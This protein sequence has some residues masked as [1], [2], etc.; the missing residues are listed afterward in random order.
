MARSGCYRP[1]LRPFGAISLLMLVMNAMVAVSSAQNTIYL[2]PSAPKVWNGE[3][4]DSNFSCSRYDEPCAPPAGAPVALKSEQ[5]CKVVFMPGNYASSLISFLGDAEERRFLS[6]SFN[7]SIDARSASQPVDS[8]SVLIQDISDVEFKPTINDTR[9]SKM[10][11]SRSEFRFSNPGSLFIYRMKGVENKFF[12]SKDSFSEQKST[13]VTLSNCE[14]D[15]TKNDGEK[16]KEATVNPA[17]LTFFGQPSFEKNTNVQLNFLSSIINLNRELTGLIKSNYAFDEISS[18]SLQVNNPHFFLWF[19]TSS[20]PITSTSA[21]K[22]RLSSKTTIQNATNVFVSDQEVEGFSAASTF[23]VELKS[24]SSITG[25]GSNPN[26]LARLYNEGIC[27][28]FELKS[29]SSVSGLEV[30]CN[31]RE[32]SD[33]THH[34]KFNMLHPDT[35][36]IDNRLCLFGT[37]GNSSTR[38][39]ANYR[40]FG[41]VELTGRNTLAKTEIHDAHITTFWSLAGTR[42]F[43][44][45]PFEPSAASGSS[46]P[47]FFYSGSVSIQN[48]IETNSIR[49]V[50]GTLQASNLVLTPL[51]VPPPPRRRSSRLHEQHDYNSREYSSSENDHHYENQGHQK[52]GPLKVGARIVFESKD[53]VITGHADRRGAWRFTTPIQI[54]G[55]NNAVGEGSILNLTSVVLQLRV[56]VPEISHPHLLTWNNGSSLYHPHWARFMSEQLIIAWDSFSSAPV[57]HV[58]YPLGPIKL[59]PENG[60]VGIVST[61]RFSE[62]R[63]TFMARTTHK[64]LSSTSEE[65]E[66]GADQQVYDEILFG[67]NLIRDSHFDPRR[68]RRIVTIAIVVCLAIGA[69]VL[70]LL[71][72]AFVF[73]KCE[74]R[75]EK[76]VDEAQLPIL[77]SDYAQ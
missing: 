23:S 7:S 48:I 68:I 22:I 75:A 41:L 27:A 64:N 59:T 35:K 13:E 11:V 6:L 42:F 51:G 54:I 77:Y 31:H 15:L 49:M 44:S 55:A 1:L 76:D 17:L 34:C 10:L 3:C 53:A 8:L 69:F 71:S 16:T 45:F 56:T 74:N 32:S 18:T 60:A 30:N 47:D 61:P 36:A 20:S 25:Y 57:P 33:P 37:N 14:F 62:R 70:L 4:L 9:P 29:G 72:T 26:S 67:V 50:D 39:R 58:W 46:S 2:S 43:R 52:S 5:E 63:Y 21:M 73:R 65:A 66:N 12:F 40:M 24:G 28:H 38:H 19:N